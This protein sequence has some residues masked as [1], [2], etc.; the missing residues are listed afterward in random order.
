[1]LSQR[2]LLLHAYLIYLYERVGEQGGITP[3]NKQLYQSL[4]SNELAFLEKQSGLVS[5]I[6]S[7]GDA[8]TASEE[9]ESHY[10]I[11]SATIRQIIAG[12]SLGQL[13]VIAQ[14]FDRQVTVA[15]TLFS[16]IQRH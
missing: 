3:V 1:M 12:I 14:N 7:I 2:D 15:Q 5:S 10:R 13:T 6:N 11:L 4:L 8:T 9:L 16:Q